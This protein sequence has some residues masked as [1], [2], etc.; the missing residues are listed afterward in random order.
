MPEADFQTGQ[1]PSLMDFL[2]NAMSATTTS[3]A[4]TLPGTTTTTT[5]NTNTNTAESSCKTL[6]HFAEC[7]VLASL[8]GH[9]VAHRRLAQS[10]T[11]AH[12]TP[13]SQVFWL[14]RH[15]WLAAATR[16]RIEEHTTRLASSSIPPPAPDPLCTFAR[17]LACVAAVSI[18]DAAEANPWQT[19]EDSMAQRQFTYPIATELVLYLQNVPRLAFPKV[20]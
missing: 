8:C 7:I 4:C 16:A 18:S 14:T 20:C 9:S 10:S 6:P 17:V 19:L 12:C 5:N 3:P 13:D 1:R 2:P 15:R 11:F